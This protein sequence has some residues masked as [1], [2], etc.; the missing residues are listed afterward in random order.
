MS[1]IGKKGRVRDLQDRKYQRSAMQR[2]AKR[3][4]SEFSKT[5]RV[6]DS[7]RVDCEGRVKM[8]GLPEQEAN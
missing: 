1:E 5:G 7:Q 3:E 4:V 2:L 8:L 6:S